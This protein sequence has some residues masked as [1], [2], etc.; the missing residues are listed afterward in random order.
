MQLIP[1]ILLQLK[2][3]DEDLLTERIE[4]RDPSL[5]LAERIIVQA[6]VRES[7]H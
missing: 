6:V 1:G 2:K 7:V 3:E 5:G 4:A